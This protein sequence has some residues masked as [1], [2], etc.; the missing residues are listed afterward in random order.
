VS[1]LYLAADGGQNLTEGAAELIHSADERV[2]NSVEGN[3]AS[4]AALAAVANDLDTGWGG[5]SDEYS[6]AFLAVRE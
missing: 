3:G 6:A 4:I 1:T 2:L 5:S